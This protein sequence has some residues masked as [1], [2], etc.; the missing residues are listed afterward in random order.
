MARHS[1]TVQL[2]ALGGPGGTMTDAPPPGAGFRP[3]A[4]TVVDDTV[5]PTDIKPMPVRTA[6]VGAP[7]SGV[8]PGSDASMF[9]SPAFRPLPPRAADTSQGIPPA[10]TACTFPKTGP[11]PTPTGITPE[12]KQML[13]IANDP[14]ERRWR[15]RRSSAALY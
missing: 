5:T 1:L 9:A 4:A 6:Q 2:A 12:M 8:L 10:P 15:A 7:P 13:A 14:H 11:A 3:P